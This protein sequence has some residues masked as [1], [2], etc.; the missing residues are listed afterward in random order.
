[1]HDDGRPACPAAWLHPGR[2]VQRQARPEY[3]R[4]PPATQATLTGPAPG[5]PPRTPS[6]A[7]CPT[8]RWP[9]A[10]GARTSPS[11]T[12]GGGLGI[13]AWRGY[14]SAPRAWMPEEDRLLGTMSDAALPSGWAVPGRWSGTG[15][16]S[17]VSRHGVFKA[18]DKVAGRWP[19]PAQTRLPFPYDS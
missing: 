6:W 8:R 18:G 13:P 7:Q 17:S 15:G 3:P 2:G 12:A 4:L 9:S 14:T 19:S 11:A 5:Y 16:A 10:W 1:R